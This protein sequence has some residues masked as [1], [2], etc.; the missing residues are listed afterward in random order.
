MR[1]DVSLHQRQEQR[2]MLLP[3]MLQAIEIL[4][5]STMDLV[6]MVDKDLAENE[7]LEVAEAAQPEP[8]STEPQE[9]EISQGSQLDADDY[10]APPR[11]EKGK[12]EEVFDYLSQVPAHSISLH[13]HLLAQLGLLDLHESMREITSFLI[14]SLDHNGHLGFG[15]EE[16]SAVFPLG[17]VAG[18]LEV[19]R[20]LDPKGIGQEGPIDSMLAQLDPSD[21][22]HERLARIV[23]DYLPDLAKNRLPKV[24]KA[25]GLPIDGLKD[26]LPK[27]RLLDPCP[28]KS[29]QAD[30][31]ERLV[32]D[33]IVR[34]EDGDWHVYLDN[35]RVPPLR[36]VGE[37]EDLSKEREAGKEVREYLREKIGSARS[38]IRAI[39]QRQETLGR[40]VRAIVDRQT[41]FLERGISGLRPMKMQEIA[42]AIGVHL[43]TVSRATAHKH[44]QTDSGVFP[45]R[46]LF[47]G[48]KAIGGDAAGAGGEARSS[49]KQRIKKI[50][51]DEPI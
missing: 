21:G 48:G 20:R 10:Y 4:Q 24:A 31:V 50:F 5:L 8:Q 39:D 11:S 40:V 1:I 46:S 22:D 47:D 30:E 6:A 49:L 51:A 44:I 33:I 23:R 36:V 43:S 35:A 15:L 45:L 32:P 38:L 26:L 17:P 19:L 42:D 7:T 27:L 18:A 14:G 25:L 13:G 16:L 28:G 3:Q 9:Q 2:L 41:G 37:Y 34:R 29:F 12:G